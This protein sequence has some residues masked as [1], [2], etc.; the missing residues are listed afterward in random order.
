MSKSRIFF[1]LS[2]SFIGGV[3]G[4]SFLYPKIIESYFLFLALTFSIML[5]VIFCKSKPAVVTGFCLAVFVFG[6]YFTNLKLN[7]LKNL[8]MDGKEFSGEAIITKEPE[9][10][11]KYQKIIVKPVETPRRGVSAGEKIGQTPKIL[12]NVF[13]MERYTYGDMLK[14]NCALKIPENFSADFDYRM[15]LAKDGI[16][17]ECQKPKVE[18]TGKNEG[19]AVYKFILGVKN[20]FNE[21]IERLIPS[22]EA[23]LLSGLLLGGDSLLSKEW[24]DRF[25]VT[26]MT[27]IVAV[28][29]YNV[30]IIAEYLMLAGIFL[31]LWRPQAFW[32]A[33]IGIAI[34]VFMI[35][36][37]AS[38]VR[39]GVMGGLLLWAAKNGRLA[40]SQNAILFSAVAM[41]LF[42]PL[43]L[44]WDVGFQLSFL[45]TLGIVYLYPLFQDNLI[46]KY[47]TFG[48]TEMLILTLS[49]Q[50]F[51][52]PIILFNFGRLSLIS[53][54]ANI[55]VL[56][57]IP[58][59]MLFGFL[60]ALAGFLFTSLATVLA[61][62]A[63]LPLKYE[64][65][66]IKYLAG[67]RYAS[68]EAGLP[69][70]GAGIWYM[71]LFG[72]VFYLGKRSGVEEN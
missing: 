2:L 64:T 47:K 53:P 68:I 31:G 24:Q 56:P 67:L 42:N 39:A 60:A 43:L 9:Q 16:F 14:V 25:S 72:V 35:G 49:A 63:Y 27:H 54:L 7:N 21:K 57:I 13:D 55:L 29:G 70:W 18:K 19:N 46:K 51:V 38:A 36:L 44:R 65:L 62:L 69:W 23:G 6:A 11:E 41:L 40:N 17:Y 28:S 3:F 15:Y 50:A 58:L 48:I 52:L 22:P 10:R 20:K 26:G 71:A 4:A 59:T 45:A 61:W 8:D 32:F 66:I 30:T 1:W 33:L 37:P 12:L 34:F 5:L